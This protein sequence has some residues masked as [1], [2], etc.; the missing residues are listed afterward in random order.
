MELHVFRLVTCSLLPTRCE[1]IKRGV[2]HLYLLTL[3]LLLALK[4]SLTFKKLSPI[5]M[6]IRFITIKLERA[7]LTHVIF[8]QNEISKKI[9]LHNTSETH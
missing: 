4:F 8:L 7:Y 1:V 6:A 3:T 5:S 9:I 2:A